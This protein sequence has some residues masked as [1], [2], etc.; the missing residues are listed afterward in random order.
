MT[1][2]RRLPIRLRL[3]LAFVLVMGA[4]LVATGAFVYLSLRSHLDHAIDQNL[5]SKAGDVT[6]L[7]RSAD[8]GLSQTGDS[9]LTEGGETFAQIITPGGR[10]YDA[11]PES[12]SQALLATEELRRAS[13]G[14]VF[15]ARTGVE[16]PLRLLATPVHAQGRRLVVVVGASLGDRNEAL[17]NLA[18]LLLIGGPAALLLASLAGYG[19]AAAALR[20]VESMRRKAAEVSVTKPGDRLPVPRASD[21]IGRLGETLNEM[22]ARQEAAF[23]RERTFVSD[24]SHE[25]R[26]PLAIL[27]T[28]LELA[29]KDGRTPGELEAALR[30]AAEE[31]DRLNRLAEYLLIIARSDQGQL[32]VTLAHLGAR[33]LL[34]RVQRR[35]ASAAD[36]TGRGLRID[37]GPSIGVSADEL[38]VE[39]AL[40]NLVENALR[41][42]EGDISLSVEESGGDVELHVRDRGPGFPKSFL[43]S[44]FDR[45]TRADPGRA[46]S[47]AGL[48]L[49][50]VR[51]VAT[52]HGGRAAARNRPD[53]GA[54]VWIS[55]P[56]EP[57]GRSASPDSHLL[58]RHSPPARTVAR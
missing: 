5:R 11:T 9:P 57:A 10:L 33:D 28:E 3:T 47:G 2:R 45:F 42:G 38:K 19:V 22:L 23:Q 44:A 6:T 29:L 56:R 53:G 41:H 27:R 39:Q 15:L 12:R 25:L 55:L 48:G 35:F 50:I 13:R 20:P 52:A 46:G 32:R 16:G 43:D 7:V 36:E 34:E 26:T 49:A 17:R 58:I 4:V 24:A 21:E 37:P 8:R 30:S 14:S 31:T 54:D 18:T 40:G 1:S 51:A